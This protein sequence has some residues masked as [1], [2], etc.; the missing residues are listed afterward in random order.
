[1]AWRAR[2]LGEWGGGGVVGSFAYSFGVRSRG[3]VVGSV[4]DA[5]LG[6]PVVVVYEWMRCTVVDH[7]YLPSSL[8]TTL[9]VCHTTSLGTNAVFYNI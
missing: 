1:M 2:S 6:R 5:C 9:T 3:L 8:S 4:A 7:Y